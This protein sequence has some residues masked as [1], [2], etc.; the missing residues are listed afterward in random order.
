MVNKNNTDEVD[1]PPTY[2]ETHQFPCPRSK[3]ISVCFDRLVLTPVKTSK[4][5]KK[6]T[7][8]ISIQKN[9]DTSVKVYGPSVLLNFKENR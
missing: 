3:G 7:K 6:Q 5:R 1:I 9:K 8:G 2:D 4:G